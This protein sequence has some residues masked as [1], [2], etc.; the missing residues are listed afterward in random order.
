[1][2]NRSMYLAGAT[3]LAGVCLVGCKS[4]FSWGKKTTAESSVA[5]YSGL[6]GQAGQSGT[7]STNPFTKAW[8]ST[9]SSMSS[10]FKTKGLADDDATNLD[11]KGGKV[12][13]EV[14]VEAA[15]VFESQGKLS[16]AK[17]QYEQA[18]KLS[19]KDE[20][21][22]IGLARLYDSMGEPA[23]AEATYLKCK[24]AH[25]KSAVVMN[26]LGLHYAKQKN[27]VAATSHFKDAVKLAPMKP[28]YR[29][30]LAAQLVQSGKSAEALNELKALNPPATAHYNLACLQHQYGEPSLASQNLR[31]A[32]SLDQNMKAASDLLG[33]IEGVAPVSGM[34]GNAGQ[35]QFTLPTQPS[36]QV[37]HYFVGSQ[38]TTNVSR[39]S[40]PSP[41]DVYEGDAVSPASSAPASQPR[42]SG[43]SSVYGGVGN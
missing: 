40:L 22:L 28:N 7:A 34:A 32:L 4:P 35:G 39:P 41:P 36:T 5:Q 11:F 38:S 14:Y 43:S 3:L 9:T 21:A 20:N 19:P 30:N 29:N 23:K 37:K 15:S 24:K 17:A 26:D 10:A 18:L 1:M 16:D 13:H 42:I 27:A 25:P 6:S 2:K 12:T 33:Q 8:K 31:T